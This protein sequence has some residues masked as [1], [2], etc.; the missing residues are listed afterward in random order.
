MGRLLYTFCSEDGYIKD[1]YIEVCN[2]ILD[3]KP[4]YRVFK[5][6][7]EYITK[8]YDCFTSSK[9]FGKRKRVM[10]EFADKVVEICSAFNVEVHNS[11]YTSLYSDFV[12]P[13]VKTMFS[14]INDIL[15][16][17]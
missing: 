16:R 5:T 8:E 9:Y 10:R 14:Y 13:N 2:Y 7:N 11:S 15:S 1:E 6:H 4:E 17:R 12:G 3:A